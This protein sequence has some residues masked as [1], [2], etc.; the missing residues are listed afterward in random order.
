MYQWYELEY[1]INLSDGLTQIFRIPLEFKT[2]SVRRTQILTVASTVLSFAAL[3]FADANKSNTT[4]L[5]KQQALM[6]FI[7]ECRN[8]YTY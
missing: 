6:V 1:D 4:I 2:G 5:S 7:N 3:K 8:Q